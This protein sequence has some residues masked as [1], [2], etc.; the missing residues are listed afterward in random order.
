LHHRTIQINRQPDAII[1]Q[2]IIL[3]FIYSS[4][5][6]GRHPAHHK[7]HDCHHD[8]KVKSEVPT[9]VIELLMMGRTTPEKFWAVNKRQNN[10][11]KNFLILFVIYLNRTL[12][13]TCLKPRSLTCWIVSENTRDLKFVT[14]TLFNKMSSGWQLRP[15]FEANQCCGQKFRLHPQNFGDGDWVCPYLETWLAE[16]AVSQKR[17]LYWLIKYTN[18]PKIHF[19]ILWY[20]LFKM[21]S[22]T[23]FGR[24]YYKNT[25]VNCVTIA[26]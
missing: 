21:F 25:V 10:K 13:L 11:Q 15:L 3:T 17:F 22:P 6:F 9:T 4:T 12:G 24:H 16:A 5:C 8:T 14:Q 19:N 23:C 18:D 20:I 7:Q 2:F 26:P 1:F